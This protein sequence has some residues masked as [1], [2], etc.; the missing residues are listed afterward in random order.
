M[1]SQCHL[2]TTQVAERFG[3]TRY[4]I[5]SWISEGKI[6]ATRV[7]PHGHYRVNPSDVETALGLKPKA[8]PE[9]DP[10]LDSEE[11]EHDHDNDP[12]HEDNAHDNE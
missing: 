2:T 4:T 12:D 7:G 11:E 3:V 9:P 10:D 6:P 8:V 1:Q 5:T